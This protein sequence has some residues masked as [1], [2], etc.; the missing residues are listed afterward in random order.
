LAIEWART[1][2]RAIDGS[3][4][5]LLLVELR[6]NAL[7]SLLQQSMRLQTALAAYPHALQAYPKSL[8]AN[9][10]SVLNVIPALPISLEPLQA[11]TVFTDAAGST[12]KFAVVWWTGSEWEGQVR[13][14]T[15]VSLQRLEMLAICLALSLF[16]TE[17][18]NIVT[19][20]QYC[21][22]SAA[23][24]CS[25]IAPR[26][27]TTVL[28]YN[29][30]SRRSQPVFVM[31]VN[32][33]LPGFI[34]A[35]NAA[36]DL[37]CYPALVDTRVAAAQSHRQFHQS[38]LSLHRLFKIPLADAQSIIAAC[39]AYSHP[40]P[41]PSGVNPRGL[42]P[43]E[44]W[45]MDITEYTPF[46]RFRFLHVAVD[47]CS[48]MMWATALTAQK[49]RECIHALCIA[50]AVMGIP[51]TLKTDN[52]PGYTSRLFGQWCCTWGITHIL[53]IPHNSTGQAIIEHT[54]LTL[55]ACLDALKEGGT[56]ATGYGDSCLH[57]L[58]LKAL[59]SLNHLEGRSADH[60]MTERAPLGVVQ[61]CLDGGLWN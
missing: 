32:S 21:F 31:H 36:A 28:L 29:A 3:E 44:L 47:T 1:K 49:A 19:D 35:G 26:T 60:A 38:A 46:G 9:L 24:C 16:P 6:P 10:F 56:E 55:K 45:Q 61:V 17:P 25:C 8:Y 37:A 40:A 41:L 23:L 39:P 15:S 59:F 33:Q 7:A 13:C 12:H 48:G 11:R 42:R 5:R 27:E 14:N 53:G 2:V 51:H 57:A 43:N 20:S 18:L 22:R 34:T 30:L 54:H 58:L 4:P 52:G 50:V